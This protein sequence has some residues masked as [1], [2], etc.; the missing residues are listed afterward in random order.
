MRK[1]LAVLTAMLFPAF[2]SAQEAKPVPLVDYVSLCLA[3]WVGAPDV[4]AK[5]SALG[6]QETMGP[7]SS[8]TIGKS[9]LQ[10]Y[11]STQSALTFIVT[12][13]KFADG[14]E[15]ACDIAMP[16]VI[17]RADL[18]TMV[19]TLHL[20]GQLMS[21]SATVVGHWKMPDRQPPVL[22]KGIIGKSVFSLEVRQFE[23]AAKGSTGRH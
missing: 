9:T 14:E 16:T 3:Q 17:N 11:K 15:R 23:P 4:Q 1:S 21:F 6:L 12:S 10:M 2:A 20:D 13:T 19:Q 5:A 22:L 18:D 7:A 8:V